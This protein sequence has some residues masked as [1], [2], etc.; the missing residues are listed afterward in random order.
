[1]FGVLNRFADLITSNYLSIRPGTGG[2]QIYVRVHS[3]ALFRNRNKQNKNFV[4]SN[5]GHN[6]CLVRRKTQLSE[7]YLASVIT[8]N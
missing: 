1:M 3:I 4:R 8:F 5:S 2:I 6:S 7:L